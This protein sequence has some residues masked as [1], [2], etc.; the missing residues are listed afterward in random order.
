MIN[1]FTQRYDPTR[2]KPSGK[3]PFPSIPFPAPY[4]SYPVNPID[5]QNEE[6]KSMLLRLEGKIDRLNR[7]I[8]YIFGEGAFING[9]FINLKL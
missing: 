5:K 7:K 3:R 4:S 9:K 1:C 6:L 2:Q 8:N